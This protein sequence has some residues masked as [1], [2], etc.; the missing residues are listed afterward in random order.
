M[1]ELRERATCDPVTGLQNQR[2]FD[3]AL[4]AIGGRRSGRWAV[5][6]A[7][8][9]GF[10]A[11]NDNHGHLAGD[12]LLRE[13]A[14]ALNEA[15]RPMDRIYRVGGDEFAAILPDLEADGATEVGNRLCKAAKGVLGSYGAS[16]SVGI[17]LPR[18]NESATEFVSRADEKLYEAK[19]IEP[20]TSRLSD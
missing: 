20:G 4:S 7:D 14:E 8:I 18:G 5:V 15:L 11:V 13:L 2:A 1:S 19:R 3:E 6:M 10:K 17:A 9:D 16:L 12:R